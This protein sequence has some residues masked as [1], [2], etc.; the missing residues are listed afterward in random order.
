[1]HICFSLKLDF[2]ASATT[3]AH[4]KWSFMLFSLRLEAPRL[5]E[6]SRL[7]HARACTPEI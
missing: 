5:G 4:A 1:M 7:S 6:N 3:R 2:L